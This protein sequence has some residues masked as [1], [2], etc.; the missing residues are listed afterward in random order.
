MA[1]MDVRSKWIS[2]SSLLFAFLQSLCTAVLAIS[3]I[4]ILIGV[5]SLAAAFTS[6]AA[7]QHFHRDVIRIP[8]MLLALAGALANLYA[9][10]RVRSL[11]KRPASQWRMQPVTSKQKRSERLQLVLSIAT[12]ILLCAEETAHILLHRPH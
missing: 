9:F 5:G 7:V 6:S 11:R 10:W 4:R 1:Q 12:L 2:W 3:G 8:M